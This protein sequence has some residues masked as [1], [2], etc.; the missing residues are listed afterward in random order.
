MDN[1]DV[2]SKSIVIFIIVLGNGSYKQVPNPYAWRPFFGCGRLL[3]I[4]MVILLLVVVSRCR[5][6]VVS[7]CRPVVL[8]SCYRVI[9]S[10]CHI[11]IISS[12]HHVIISII[13]ASCHCVIVWSC[14]R[15]GV[16]SCHRVLM[17]SCHLVIMSTCQL[18]TMFVNGW[19][20]LAIFD[21]FGLFSKVTQHLPTFGDFAISD[22]F[23]NIWQLLSSC[24]V[25][26]LSYC[27]LYTLSFCPFVILSVL[28]SVNLSACQ[29][30]SLWSFQHT[31]ELVLHI[32]SVISFGGFLAECL[33]CL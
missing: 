24:C 22:N 7:W 14:H 15:V 17:S 23:C 9:L 8:S 5:P 26:I 29:F 11:V 12:C 20:L 32:R 25:V 13:M 18:V 16:S 21:N 31:C 6:V 10:F 28:Q 2:S 33:P 27:H 30:A 1:H 4:M 3:W 19:K